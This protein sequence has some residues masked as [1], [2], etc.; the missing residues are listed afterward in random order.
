M[1]QNWP[2]I[3]FFPVAYLDGS[4]PE[5]GIKPNTPI[6][7]VKC[8]PF[9]E[10]G[11]E[12]NRKTHFQSLDLNDKL[13]FYI[14]DVLT[15]E[16]AATIIGMT[17]SLGYDAAAPGLQTPPGM[18]QNKTVHWIAD[19][20]MMQTLFERIKSHL[21][22]MI[23]GDPLFPKLSHR[24]NMYRYD[25]GDEFKLHIDGDWPGYGLSQDGKDLIQWPSVYSKLTMLLYLNGEENGIIGGETVLYDKGEPQISIVPKTGRALFFRHGHSKGSVLHAGAP[26]TG[27]VSKYVA[28][29]NIMY[30]IGGL[31]E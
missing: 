23:E 16:E 21:P 9:L 15:P 22:Q 6:H 5:G 19:P 25:E 20:I 1:Q 7:A 10:S 29:I 14:D 12:I 28:R 8:H 18:R 2:I 24:I 31:P 30:E 4:Y 26:L 17:E 3:E 27:P 11:D 13:A